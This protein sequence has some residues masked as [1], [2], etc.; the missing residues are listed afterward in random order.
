MCYSE[1]LADQAHAYQTQNGWV[2]IGWKA[3]LKDKY[4]TLLSL[5]TDREG[6]HYDYTPLKLLRDRH[7]FHLA[8]T[9]EGAIRA[10]LKFL[11]DYEQ[12]HETA[13]H[14]IRRLSCYKVRVVRCLVPSESI[15]QGNH[16]HAMLVLPPRQRE[17]EVLIDLADRENRRLKRKIDERDRAVRKLR[18][19]VGVN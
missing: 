17:T 18:N 8:A 19:L 5:R 3:V 13:L 11:D 4:G 9:R 15:G 7:G 1:K 16:A 12:R 2:Y 6:D 10:A 14:A